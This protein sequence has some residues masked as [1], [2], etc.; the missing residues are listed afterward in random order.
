MT[1]IQKLIISL[2]VITVLGGCTKVNSGMGGVL[3][4]ETD[5]TLEFQIDNTI[6]PDESG[7]SSPVFV[8]LYELRD[9]Q[10]F[11]SSNFIDLYE[12]DNDVLSSSLVSKRELQRFVPGVSREEKFVLDKE[13]RYVALYAEFFRYKDAKYKVVFPITVNNIVR[14]SVTV[15]VASNVLEIVE[16]T[17]SKKSKKR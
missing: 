5:L 7:H 16:G 13:T 17:P 12:K 10:L 6:N 3:S 11:D 8:R 1:I 2:F 4:L 15:R 9:T 14:N